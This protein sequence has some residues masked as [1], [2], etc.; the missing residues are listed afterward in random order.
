MQ[1]EKNAAEE[2]E[3]FHRAADI[4]FSAAL[5]QVERETAHIARGEP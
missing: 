3:W 4:T 2:Y 1:C 5:Q